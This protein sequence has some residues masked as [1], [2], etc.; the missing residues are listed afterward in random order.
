MEDD[1]FVQFMISGFDGESLN[2]KICT[3]RVGL[4]VNGS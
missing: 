1:I 4:G 3:L 2:S